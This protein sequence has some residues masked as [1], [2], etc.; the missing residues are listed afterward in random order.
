MRRVALGA[1]AALLAS[2]CGRSGPVKPF[3][4]AP[5]VLVSIDTLRAD[6]LPAYGLRARARRRTSMPSRA[7]ACVFEDVVSACP[8]TLPA[9]ASM[10][11]GLLPPRHGVRD[12]AG[13]TLDAARRPLA[14]RFHETGFATGAAVS[15]YVLRRATGIAQGFDLPTTRFRSMRR[16]RGSGS[17]S[18]TARPPSSRWAPGWTP[19]RASAFFAFLHLYEPH[20]PYAPPPAFQRLA[21]PY[22]GEVAYADDLVGRLFDRLRAAGIFDRAI[23]AVTSDHGEGLGDHGEKEHGFFVYRESVHVPLIVRLPDRP[24]RWHP[25]AR[26]RPRRWT[27]PPR[28]WTWPACP[29]TAWTASR[30]VPRSS[31]VA[32][33]RVPRTPRRSTRATTSDGASCAVTDDRLRLIDAPRPELYDVRRRPARDP[34]PRRV[35]RSRGR[36]DERN[37]STASRAGRRRRR[38][39]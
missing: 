11:T 12:N 34:E 18:G 29:P 8:L 1:A 2:A 14:A 26:R 3:Q 38:P 25:R 10:F 24:A 7:R 21:Q 30:S 6:R 28:C 32:R 36:G 17:S 20:A 13:F 35:A 4:D 37:G 31:P 23:V 5:V 19:G 16:A 22:D 15:A 9:H 33:R 39:P 27:C